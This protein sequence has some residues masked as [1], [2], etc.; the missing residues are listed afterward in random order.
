MQGI[1]DHS[2]P[3]GREPRKGRQSIA[4]RRKPWEAEHPL[5]LSP[6]RGD[7]NR[8]D[9]APSGAVLPP[10][11]GLGGPFVAF[12]SR[13]SRPLAIDF[14]LYRGLRNR[15]TRGLTWG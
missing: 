6:G 11:P 12:T 5:R 4:Q 13:G 10:H 7:S 3:V 9:S 8:A 14:R 1:G 2:E 15:A